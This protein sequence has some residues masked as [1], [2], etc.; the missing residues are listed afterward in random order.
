M[1]NHVKYDRLGAEWEDIGS[2]GDRSET[3][4][5]WFRKDTLDA[6]RHNRMR[7]PLKSVIDEKPQASWLTVGDG[8][9]GTDGHALMEMGAENVHCSD[10]SD[11]LLAIGKEKGFIDEYSAQN[12]EDLS[13]D[14]GSFDYVYCKESFHHFPRPYVALDEMFRVCKKAVVLTEPRDGSVDKGFFHPF[15]AALK[16]LLGRNKSRGHGFEPA[17]NYIYSISER[18]MEKFLLGMHYTVIAFCS[19]N[20]AYK[21]GI[22]F[23][24]MGSRKKT[25]RR[26]RAQIRFSIFVQDLLVFLKLYKPRLLTVALF[27]EPPSESLLARMRQD[28]WDVRTLPKN[29]YL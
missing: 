17:G 22:E 20:D 29:P 4:Q 18:E 8:R 23:V 13:F 10:I 16:M 27:K 7:A 1:S 11:A 19:L 24:E 25:D 15:F 5:T 9:Y 2:G 6:W 26:L 28:G 12:A 14:D 21:E 3:A